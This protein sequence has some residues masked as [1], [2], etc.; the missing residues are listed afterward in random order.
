MTIYCRL[1]SSE[2][3]DKDS[4]YL[5]IIIQ[6]FPNHHCNTNSIDSNEAIINLLIVMLSAFFQLYY[7]FFYLWISLLF[8]HPISKTTLKIQ[9][10]RKLS[11][12]KTLV[13]SIYIYKI[14]TV[15]LFYMYDM[16]VLRC[17]R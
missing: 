6:S 1:N 8:S 15:Q 2:N 10:R 4:P 14:A 16:V 5:Y 12:L 7:P 11:L 9:K 3:N 17:L 13:S